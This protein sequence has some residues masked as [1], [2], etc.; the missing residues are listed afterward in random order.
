MHDVAV[1][2]CTSDDTHEGQSTS[3]NDHPFKGEIVLRQVLVERRYDLARIHGFILNETAQLCK[4]RHEHVL[5]HTN[6]AVDV[7]QNA[8]QVRQGGK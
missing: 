6:R 4:R 5:T 8:D 2:R 7:G 1:P 3:A